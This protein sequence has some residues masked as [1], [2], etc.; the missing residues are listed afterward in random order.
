MAKSKK[1]KREK[2]LKLHGKL[3]DLLSIALTT[4]QKKRRKKSKK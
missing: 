3:D 1:S 4:P 2:P